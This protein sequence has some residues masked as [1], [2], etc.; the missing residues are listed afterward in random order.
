MHYK[1]TV[2][3]NIFHHLQE[4]VHCEN[5]HILEPEKTSCSKLLCIWSLLVQENLTKICFNVL[6]QLSD[7]VPDNYCFCNES[8]SASRQK[9]QSY[10]CNTPSPFCMPF[11]FNDPGQFTP[12]LNLHPCIFTSA[13]F[14]WFISTYLS[15]FV[16]V[17]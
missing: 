4:A 6:S 5:P 7:L 3:R 12:L 17:E 8:N 2:Y 13:L 9:W 15:H 14:G 1:K 16:L 10:N 11:C